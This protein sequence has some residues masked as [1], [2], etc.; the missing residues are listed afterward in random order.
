MDELRSTFATW[1][2]IHG[3]V[4]VVTSQLKRDLGVG[5]PSPLNHHHNMAQELNEQIQKLM[6]VHGMMQRVRQIPPGIL[7]SFQKRNSVWEEF[8][9]L[10][11]TGETVNSEGVQA[12][13]HRAQES[14]KVDGGDLETEVRRVSRKRR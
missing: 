12:A 14:M 10:K 9:V 1:R 7:H 4:T 8:A 13:L 11:N 6:E 5:Q 2:K 3:V